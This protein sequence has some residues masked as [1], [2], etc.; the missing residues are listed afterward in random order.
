[1]AERFLPAALLVAGLVQTASVSAAELAPRGSFRWQDPTAEFG[2]FSGLVMAPDGGAFYAVTD[3]GALFH[4][5]VKR[6]PEGRIAVIA[7]NW[8]RRLL[9]NRGEDVNGFTSDA[10]GLAPAPDGGLF[11]VYE[12]YARVNEIRPPDLVPL[13]LHKFDRF[14]AFWSNES[15]EGIAA[16]PG[17]DLIIVS[18]KTEADA[19][20]TVIGTAKTWRAGPPLP[21]GD[22]DYDASDAAL[23]PDGRFYLLERR[24]SVGGFST[25]IRRFA[26]RNGAFAESETLLETAPGALDN[27]EGISLWTD[28]A[29]KTVVSLISD[30]NFFFAQKTILAEYELL[31]SQ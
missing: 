2:G 16:L 27:M 17:G 6:D 1:M 20:P 9:T 12:S 13:P 28:S 21:A 5:G 15:F 3:K 24:L 8:H 19:Y 31:E 7:I 11:V 4:A 22:G 23:G 30:D 10:E 14:R 18:E 29:G 26:Y 25:R